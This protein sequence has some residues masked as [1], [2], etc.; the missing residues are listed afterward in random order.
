MIIVW[1]ILRPDIDLNN[2]HLDIS[3]QV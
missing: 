3:W 2:W 1:Q